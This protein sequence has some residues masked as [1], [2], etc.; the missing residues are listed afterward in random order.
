MTNSSKYHS[1]REII[2]MHA[3]FWRGNVTGRDQLDKLGIGGSIIFERNLKRQKWRRGMDYSG[4][5]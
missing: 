3:E 2:E 5:G 1:D 4:C